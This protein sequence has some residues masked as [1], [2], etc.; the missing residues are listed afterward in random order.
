MS[1]PTDIAVPDLEG[2]LAVVTGASDGIGLHIAAGLARAGAE[3]VLPVRNPSKGDAAARRIRQD[4]PGAKVDVRTMDLASLASVA[5][6]ADGLLG[7]GRPIHVL[8]NNAGVMTPPTRQ[9]SADGFEL[10]LAINHLGHAALALRLLPLLRAGGARVT[11]Q[12]SVAANQHAVAWDDVNWEHGYDA[13]KAYSSSKIALGLFALELQRRSTEAGWGISSNVSHPGVSPTNLLAAQPGMGRAK[14]TA[15]V[16]IIRALSRWNLLVGTPE[17]AEL[18][19]VYAATSRDALGGR[20]YGPSGF[21]HLRGA[22]AEQPLYSRLE[23]AEDRQRIWD[24]TEELIGVH[25]SP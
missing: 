9:L 22:P 4:V 20:F 6:F 5:E 8:I 16:R 24:L 17:S 10:Q 15:S 23:P 21:Q 13:M 14:D 18:P 1:R 19:A 3:V 12:L 25:A 2:K 11:S 7:D